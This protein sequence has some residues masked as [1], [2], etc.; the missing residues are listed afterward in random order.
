MALP[1]PLESVGSR[2]PA[3][4]LSFLP[5]PA[6]SLGVELE[7]QVVDRDTGELAPGGPRILEACAAQGLD[8]VDGELLMFMLEVKTGVCPDVAA[9]R[10]DLF[11]RLA[12]VRRTAAALG[13]DLALGGT[14]PFSRVGNDAVTPTER[15]RQISDRQAG[16]THQMGVFGLHVHVGVPD[17]ERAIGLIN[18]LTPYLPHLLA[19]SANSPLWQGIDTGFASTRAALFRPTPHSGVP[20]HCATWADFC[21]YV[22]VLQSGGA[23][24]V[25]KDIYW[26][27]R[28]RPDLGTIEFRVC[29]APPTLPVLLG[30]VALTRCLVLDGLR[31]LDERQALGRGDVGEFWMAAENKA[32]AARYGLRAEGVRRPGRPRCSLAE[33]TGLLV[34]RLL[35]VAR[36][37]GED[38]YLG[39]LLPVDE[40]ESGADRQR[41]LLR[42]PGGRAALIDDLKR[43]WVRDLNHPLLRC[44]DDV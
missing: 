36:R 41:R 5:S 37:A 19:L 29:D 13:Y 32:L 6:V 23:I 12:Q 20:Q 38:G 43:G 15:Y 3:S 10:A 2:H 16:L 11:P 1:N 18:L 7:L 28:P 25:L 39:A 22:D 30:L 34:E 17:G 26:D 35:P 31:L 40:Y 8:G 14:H 33:D 21:R 44:T 4:T 9:V 42:L 24:G 27:V